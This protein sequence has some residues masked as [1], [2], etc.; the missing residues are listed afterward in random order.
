MDVSHDF[1]KAIREKEQL[2]G[3]DNQVELHLSDD[4]LGLDAWEVLLYWV[5]NN[6][7][8]VEDNWSCIDLIRIQMAV[9]FSQD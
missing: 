3:S 8:R 1:G 4:G 5:V 9:I 7:T 6:D 2:I